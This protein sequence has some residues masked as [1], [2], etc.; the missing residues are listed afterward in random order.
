MADNNVTKKN[1]PTRRSVAPVSDI[2]FAGWQLSL[3]QGL[4]FREQW[5]GKPR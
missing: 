1:P 2:A 5:N 4:G 3:F